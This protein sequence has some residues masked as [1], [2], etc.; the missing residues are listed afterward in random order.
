MKKMHLRERLL[1]NYSTDDFVKRQKAS[2]VINICLTI[3]IILPITTIYSVYLQLQSPASGYA[4]QPLILIPEILSIILVSITLKLLIAGQFTPAAH[5]LAIIC[6]STTWIIMFVDQSMPVSRLDTIAYIF[7]LMSML[8]LIVNRQKKAILLY[9]A[10]NLLI[11]IIF[12]QHY[13]PQ[14]THEMYTDFLLDTT[15]SMIFIGIVI[16]NIFGINQRALL[17][18]AQ[19]IEERKRAEAELKE[20]ENRYRLLAENISD[21]IWTMDMDLNF[22]YISPSDTFLRGFSPQEAS[23]QTLNDVITPASMAVVVEAFNSELEYVSQNKDAE[24]RTVSLEIEQYHK[25]GSTMWNEANVHFLFDENHEPVGLLGST[26]NIDGRKQAENQLK[27]LQNFLHSI[28][29]SMPYV[30]IGLDPQG[31]VTLWNQMAA[32]QSGVQNQQAVGRHISEIIP[33]LSG[34]IDNIR[35]AI[36]DMT[37]VYR[38]RLTRILGDDRLADL[39]IYPLIDDQA[40]GAVILIEDITERAR[41][42]E[43]MIQSEKM[44][45]IGGLAAGMAHEINNPLAGITQSIQVIQARF[46]PDQPKNKEVAAACNLDLRNLQEYMNRRNL[47]PLLNNLSETTQ[48][49]AKVV[50]NMLAF[51]RKSN[52]EFE[53]CDMQELIEKTIRLAEN[54][55]SLHR[56]YDFK[57]IKIIRAFDD[58]L[59]SIPCETGKIQQVILNLLKNGAQAMASQPNSA[60]AITIR[61]KREDNFLR[62]EVQD[63]GPGISAQISRHIFEPFFTTKPKGEG[64]GLG[65]SVSYFII[66]K[67]HNGTM[68]VVSTPG[69][70]ACFVVRLPL[71]Q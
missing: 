12:T 49:A 54:D 28:I 38:E 15:L 17:R 29:N 2:F 70:G 24:P 20:S 30:L 61:L 69:Q 6:F 22:T 31:N 66:T 50:E 37:P 57:R 21:V 42:E 67:S 33:Q 63:N 4:L 23:R 59:P 68:E 9:T 47:Q 10:I 58:Q 8:P 34:E 52:G 51:S 14:L 65:L 36:R 71:T 45:S 16:Y 55:F 27:K 39:T 1:K 41:L 5:M 32:R 18:A 3:L 40:A 11:L 25:D 13:K 48:R 35:L 46:N 64:T 60:P 62:I 7:G 56:H 43:S 19:D 26:R 53:L 44:L